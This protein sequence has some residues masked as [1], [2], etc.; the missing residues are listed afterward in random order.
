QQQSPRGRSQEK[1][2][3]KKL[4]EQRN[5]AAPAHGLVEEA[6]RGATADGRDAAAFLAPVG[7]AVQGSLGNQRARHLKISMA[8][9]AELG[10]LLRLPADGMA[11]TA[12]RDAISFSFEL[13]LTFSGSLNF[14]PSPSNQRLLLF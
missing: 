13:C 8:S 11:V 7:A 5:R 12:R 9:D 3:R 6:A 14:F 2:Q 1:E 4:L 10:Y